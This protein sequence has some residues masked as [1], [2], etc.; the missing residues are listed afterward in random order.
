M[1]EPSPQDHPNP[2]QGREGVED[3]S[4]AVRAATSADVRANRPWATI[5]G[6]VGSLL[7]FVVVAEVM[8][9][10]TTPSA[11]EQ[12]AEDRSRV[13]KLRELHAADAKALESAGWV[14]KPK[15]VARIPIERAMELTAEES[16]RPADAPASRE[17]ARP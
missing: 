14:D 17:A 1:P 5:V 11:S 9:Y 13:E 8:H 6:V 4:L 7:V 3:A 10:F 2:A 16:S 15:G 12:A